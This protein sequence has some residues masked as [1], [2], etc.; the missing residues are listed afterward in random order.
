MRTKQ[1]I[2][3]P[4]KSAKKSTPKKALK[5]FFRDPPKSKVLRVLTY[6]GS[7]LSVVALALACIPTI[8]IFGLW[9]AVL[10]VAI[11]LFGF[12]RK[13]GKLP[14]KLLIASVTVLV[15]AVASVTA[16][17]LYNQ[18]LI[19]RQLYLQSG[20]ATEEIMRGDLSVSFGEWNE[21]GVEI[22]LKNHHPETKGYN[23]L[24]EA[25][26]E[27]GSVITNEMVSVGGISS[28]RDITLT[29]F[30][31]LTEAQKSAMPSARFEVKSVSQY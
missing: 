13:D 2:A 21:K 16:Q 27:S 26:D 24:V 22:T 10:I 12:F 8:N 3:L 11:G 1:D 29:I 20:D 28:G 4:Q 9:L 17:N 7:G 23:V 5:K 25:V 31:R 14:K 19:D 6:L 18:S 15:L 30:K